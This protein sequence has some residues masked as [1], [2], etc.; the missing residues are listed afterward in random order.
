KFLS[1]KL[2]IFSMSSS[3]PSV[4]ASPAAVP[5]NPL[6]IEEPTPR[7]LTP[8]TFPTHSRRVFTSSSL[9]SWNSR[10]VLLLS[11]LLWKSSAI[12]ETFVCRRRT[13][14]AWK[15]S[16]RYQSRVKS[17]CH[18]RLRSQV[19]SRAPSLQLLLRRPR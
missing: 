4:A 2:L 6:A 19:Q 12:N 16:S 14:I 17:Q 7:L 15:R 10:F 8:L 18:R 13:Q 5:A 9:R 3:A 1:N 11:L